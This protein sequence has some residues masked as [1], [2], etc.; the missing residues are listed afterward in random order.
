MIKQDWFNDQHIEF[1]DGFFF[2]VK[3]CSIIIQE[4]LWEFKYYCIFRVFRKLNINNL[5][6]DL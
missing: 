2:T 1:D 4:S 5:S 3:K 6:T